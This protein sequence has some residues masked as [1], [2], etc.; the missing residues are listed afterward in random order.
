MQLWRPGAE[1]YRKDGIE[2]WRPLWAELPEI[3]GDLNAQVK[4]YKY[5]Q[6][7]RFSVRMLH[8]YGFFSPKHWTYTSKKRKAVQ[9]YPCVAAWQL[10]ENRMELGGQAGCEGSEQV[11]MNPLLLRRTK[12]GPCH[13]TPQTTMMT[14][15]GRPPF[16]WR[17]EQKPEG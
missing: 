16:A 17:N 15:W 1:H 12:G 2:N 8:L 11:A 10:C 5:T 6:H 7:W 4:N 13:L 3:N 14:P 9:E